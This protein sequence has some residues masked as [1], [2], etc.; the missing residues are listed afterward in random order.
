[1]DRPLVEA[2]GVAGR[3]GPAGAPHLDEI[4]MGEDVEQPA[5]GSLAKRVEVAPPDLVDAP[6][7]P[8]DVVVGVIDGEVPDE[9]DRADDVVEVEPL[10][11]VP[12]LVLPPGDEVHLD[13]QAEVGLLADELAVR[14]DVV[15]RLLGPERVLPDLE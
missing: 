9:M 10:E 3:T 8:P 2:G 4:G 15:D 1:F 5:A 7:A 12:G 14:V 6:P 11:Q 13:P